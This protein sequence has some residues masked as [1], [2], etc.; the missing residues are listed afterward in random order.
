MTSTSVTVCFFL[1]TLS[2]VATTLVDCAVA[3]PGRSPGS[4]RVTS[5]AD[6]IPGSAEPFFSTW[7][8]SDS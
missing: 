2:T 6:E 5:A 3:P 7:I 4:A 8:T 1:S